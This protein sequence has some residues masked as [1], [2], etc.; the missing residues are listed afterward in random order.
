[1]GAETILIIGGGVIGVCAMFSLA[2][3]GAAVTLL[4][5]SQIGAGSSF[6]NA[7][8]IVPSHSLPLSAFAQQALRNGLKWLFD[9]DS[10]FYL[11]PCADRD[12]ME[13]LLRFAL[14]GTEARSRAAIPVLRDLGLASRA[15]F[16]DLSRLGFDFGYETRGL[17]KLF[18]SRHGLAE[19]EAEAALLS[20]YGLKVH[21]LDGQGIRAL[22][23]NV[24]ETVLGGLH[25]PDDAHLNPARFVR[26][27]AA[28]AEK[29][30][31]AIRTGIGVIGFEVN[32]RRITRV[33]TTGGDFTPA[34]VVLAAGIGSP[35]LA[36]D[37]QLK[38][39]IQP[40]KGYSITVRRP[41]LSPT[42]PLLLGETWV[43]VTPL[44]ETLR[45]AGTLELAGLDFS[46][47]RRRVE[48]VQRGVQP[49]LP[50]VG[51]AE[52]L[53][54]WRGLRPCT[55]DGL[56]IIERSR[57]YD[58]LLIATGHA[59]LGISLGPVT[60]ELIAQLACGESP[61]IELGPL[62]AERFS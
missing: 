55:P 17:L 54:I 1:M 31:A 29:L 20:E 48:A 22:E 15:L 41:A 7:G 10:P 62:R 14:A 51:H 58:N 11:R 45:F 8:L 2:R 53:E 46:I 23:P 47:N 5:R 40:A 3:R 61:A 28:H 56:P 36:R 52:R 18:V 6:G 34:Q 33:R 24:S 21:V 49:Y 44:G 30:G 39:P 13:W 50:D 4:E 38:L 35:A 42:L 43:A 19:A 16:D 25:F 12:L 37:L 26:G 27:L 57:Q 60:G 59:M 9:P 32:G